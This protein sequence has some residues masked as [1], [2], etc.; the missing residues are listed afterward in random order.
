MP[1]ALHDE[2]RSFA[3]F[4]LLLLIT[5]PLTSYAQSTSSP[6]ILGVLGIVWGIF[7]FLRLLYVTSIEGISSLKILSLPSQLIFGLAGNQRSQIT[8]ILKRLTRLDVMFFLCGGL[9]FIFW[10]VFCSLYPADISIIQ[11]FNLKQ[12]A[13]LD[14]TVNSRLNAL[15]I[16]TSLSF[17]GI[18]GIIILL[19]L[20]YSL[21]RTNVRW[22]FFTILPM[23]II[24]ALTL[25]ITKSMADI[26]LWPDFYILKGGGLG[27]AEILGLLS[28]DIMQHS[29]TGLLHRFTEGGIIGAYGVYVLFFSA[30][31]LMV[32]ALFN[33]NRTSFKYVIGLLVLSLLV[34]IDVGFIFSELWSGG[35]VLGVSILALCWGASARRS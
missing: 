30:F 10:M 26:I 29:G 19:S 32:K 20:S 23:F 34:F 1:F 28:V 27:Q 3:F 15:S 8:R 24:G 2:R 5:A 14:F 13:L 11:D 7:G 12:D 9:F 31:L 6:L 4:L 22:A 33:K 18:L 35:I 25:I 17:Y 21:S 16:V